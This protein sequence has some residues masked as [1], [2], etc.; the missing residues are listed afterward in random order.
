MPF[1]D[2]AFTELK[3]TDL[4]QLIFSKEAEGKEIDYKRSLPGGSDTQRKEFLY[5]VCSFA[6]SA[7]G[8]LIFGME[9]TRGLP[10]ALAGLDG[11]NPDAEIRRLEEMARDGIRP[12]IPGLQTISIDLARGN[13]AI[14]MH[15]PKSWI[16][17]HQVVFQKAF[18]FYARDSNGKYQ[19]D[20]EE[21]RT[22]FTLSA[23][24]ADRMREFRVVRVSRIRDN[25]IVAP[26]PPAARMITHLLP[27]SAFNN[28][29]EFDLRRFAHDPT[30]FVP[31]SRGIS[32]SRFNADGFAAWSDAAYAQLYRNGCL[33]VVMSLES[34]P[35]PRGRLE[36]LPSVGFEQQIFGVV[37]N[38]KRLLG[39]LSV[40]C[41][42]AIAVSFTGIKGWKMGMSPAYATS[43]LDAFDRDP[44]LLPEILIETFG[45]SHL[46]E[47]R[48][49]IDA[50]WN[51]A[52]WP[53]SPHYDE[54]GSWDGNR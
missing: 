29:G 52:G 23:S 21:L 50:V 45:G 30:L 14:V 4:M 28:V 41:P 46:A 27:L 53:G 8:Y 44:L 6:N 39:A 3:E 10:T 17:P 40:E 15:I 16:P 26:L 1:S 54:Q 18:R 38:G 24:I 31:L 49:I 19:L 20:V 12:P 37:R 34:P 51:A 11:V 9:E 2:R 32:Y 25:E 13:V 33:E 47:A 36:L 42:V 22:I 35:G 7:G 5:D 48:P 43:Q